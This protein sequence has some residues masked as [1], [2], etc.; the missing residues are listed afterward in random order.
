[1][2]YDNELDFIFKINENS[3]IQLDYIEENDIDSKFY[4]IEDFFE[5][6]DEIVKYLNKFK[7]NVWKK[8]HKLSYNTIYFQDMSQQLENI[9]AIN[10]VYDLITNLCNQQSE[11]RGCISTNLFNFYKHNFNDYY[12]NYW[13]PHKDPGYTALVYL[14]KDDYKNGT[15]IYRCIDPNHISVEP[16][17]YKPWVSKEKFEL[18]MTVPPKYNRLFL[19]NA[20]K[21]YH[22]MSIEDDRYSSG[23][24]RKNLVFFFDE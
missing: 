17:H 12:E 14:N 20:A 3:K 11:F 18:I 7:P 10:P 6:P 19:F 24:V 1:M 4:V 5:N 13:C 9:D 23:E 21:Y 22:G 2:N 15:N 8:E 16:E